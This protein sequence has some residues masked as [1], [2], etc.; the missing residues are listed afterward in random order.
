M[1]HGLFS[2]SN[3]SVNSS[4]IIDLHHSRLAESSQP[5]NGSCL[6]FAD[7]LLTPEECK[8]TPGQVTDFPHLIKENQT[9]EAG[10]GY[11]TFLLTVLLPPDQKE[12]GIAIPQMYSA[13]KLW[14]NGKVIA[15]NGTVGKTKEEYTPQWRPQTVSFKVNSD[16]LSLVLQIA[17]FDHIKGGIK[18]PIYLGKSSVMQFKRNVSE[19]SKL[20]EATA[21]S[22]I[23]FF[24]LLIFIF[25]R[26]KK[27]A[28]YFA[29]LCLTWAVRSLFSNLYLFIY[30]F[31]DFNWM[32]MI[33]VEYISL[34]LTMIWAI[35]FLS[36][37]FQSESNVIIKYGLVICNILFVLFTMSSGPRAFTQGLTVYLITSGILIIYGIYIIVRAWVNERTGSGLIT[38]SIVLGLNIFGYDIFVF[39]G[40]SSY[41][42]VIFSAGYIFI[43][44]LM[45]L[46]LASHLNLIK[47][48]PGVTTLL[49]YDDL[50]KNQ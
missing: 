13:Y 49:T 42:P 46:G 37:L 28:L 14:A 5:L 8:S 15:Q 35:L 12:L 44:L 45:A 9:K 6:F 43:F 17:N 36:S 39:E 11:A 27:V 47:S 3:Q 21:L 4:G 2:Q 20:V 50:Y 16:T 19:I 26:N 38:I 40:F 41:D 34:Y 1:A 24:F 30:Y 10:L 18:E 33:R 25:S 32:V 7:Q 23:G 29:L 31:P 22:L 48:K